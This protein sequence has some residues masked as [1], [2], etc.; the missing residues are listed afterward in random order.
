MIETCSAAVE[1][2]LP[3]ANGPAILAVVSLENVQWIA[4]QHGLRAREA[5]TQEFGSR[6]HQLIRQ[7]DGYFRVSDDHI[8]LVF[9]DLIDRNHGILAA[10]K[11]ESLFA[12]PLALEGAQIPLII[13]AGLVN[14]TSCASARKADLLYR[15]AEMARETA[16]EQGNCFEILSAEEQPAQHDI[17]LVQDFQ[18]AME[19]GLVSLDYQPKYRLSNGDLVGAEALVRWRRDGVVVPPSEFIPKLSH[20][21]TWEMTIYCIRRAIREM[22]NFACNVPIALNIDPSVL[23]RPAFLSFVRKELRLWDVHPQQLAFEIAETTAIADYHDTHELL[24][25]LRDAGHL[26]AM[27]DFGTGQATLQHLRNLPADEIKIDSQFITNLVTNED[28]RNITKSIIEM[29]HRCGKYVVAKGIE[30]GAI[31]ALLIDLG[32]DIGQ[33]F[34]LGMPMSQHQFKTLS[35]WIKD[36][37]MTAPIS[38]SQG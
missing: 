27:D 24:N 30:D 36:T 37:N 29:A 14:F 7:G 18:R 1:S 23:D 2:F 26:I 17:N 10:K 12:S 20:D 4:G 13:R 9:L 22:Q 25:V 35:G 5:A 33:G 34:F 15:A 8:C 16:R 32:C 38:A 19:D 3:E 11:L 28:D 31:V 6:L 21:Q